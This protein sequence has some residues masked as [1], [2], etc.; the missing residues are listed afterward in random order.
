[1]TGKANRRPPLTADVV[2]CP[3]LDTESG[4]TGIKQQ[5]CVVIG[6]FAT[7]VQDRRNVALLL[8]LT[9]L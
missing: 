4:S 3:A 9:S 6:E 2:L 7:G 1:M 8:N 5:V